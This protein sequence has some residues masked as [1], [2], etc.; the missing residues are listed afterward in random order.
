VAADRHRAWPLR[1]LW[2][3]WVV[4]L[5]LSLGL[6]LVLEVLSAS[7]KDARV[8]AHRRAGGELARLSVAAE[9]LI[10][11]EPA[12]LAELLA[13]TML[14]PAIE[15][16]FIVDP[17]RRIVLSSRVTDKGQ[18]LQLAQPELFALHAQT[19]TGD[20][21][22]QTEDPQTR[23]L[24][25]ARS[26]NWPAGEGELRG[27]GRGAVFVVVDMGHLIDGQWREALTDHLGQA[28]V[29]VL[30]CLLLFLGLEWLIARPVDRLREA[31]VRLGEGDL[32][33]R[34]PVTG[35]RELED[36][37]QAVNSMGA[38]LQAAVQRLQD[39]EQRFRALTESAP[40]AIITLDDGGRVDQFNGAAERLFGFSAA[41]MTGQLL[42][43]L[44]PPGT[45][46]VH[47]SLLARFAADM[48]GSGRRMQAG[49]VVKGL[50]RDGHLLHL[51]IGIS[52]SQAGGARSYTAMIRDV[53]DRVAVEDELDKHRRQLEDQVRQRTAEL[54]LERDRAQAAMRA[55]NEFLARMSH[56]IRTPMNAVVGLA[57]V[58][59]RGA[60]PSQVNQLQTLE[61]SALQLLALVDDILEFT[62]LEAGQVALLAAPADP[63]ALVHAVCQP[64]AERAARLGVELVEWVDAEVPDSVS[65][66]AQR[67]RQLLGHLVGN[68]VKFTPAGHITVHVSL[69]PT[70]LRF[71]VQDSGIGIEPAALNRLFKPFEQADPGDARRF[72]GA[73]L[74][75]V[76]TQRL[77]RLMGAELQAQSQPGQGSRFQFEV[78][79]PAVQGRGAPQRPLLPARQALVVESQADARAAQ[80]DL[81]RHLGVPAEGAASLQEARESLARFA[82]GGRPVDLCLVDAR[83]LADESGERADSPDPH[84]TLGGHRCVLAVLEGHAPPLAQ[85]LHAGYLGV[86]SKPL[87]CDAVQDRLVAWLS[88]PAPQRGATRPPA[89]QAAPAAPLAPGA[90]SDPV[91]MEA[92]EALHAVPGLDVAA[93]LRTLRGDVP[94]YRRLLRHFATFHGEDPARL[95]QL[96]ERGAGQDVADLAHSLKSSAG[97][98]GARAVVAAASAVPRH[99]EPLQ[100]TRRTGADLAAQMSSLLM[101]L[102]EILNLPG[103]A[104][105]APSAGDAGA[106]L[107]DTDPAELLLQLRA[108]L[109]RRDMAALRL[110]HASRGSLLAQLGAQAPRLRRAVEDFDF[111]VAL[112]LLDETLAARESTAHKPA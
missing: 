25:L 8:D 69:S 35:V 107:E 74:G 19:Q 52:H 12:V 91:G 18:L 77:L 59:R 98:I 27:P 96:L 101:A 61:D 6:W 16:A 26:L 75:L 57:H 94:A 89:P 2:A 72:G 9:S 78:R 20:G 14:D 17:Q 106:G 51:E 28:L 41:E 54:V 36:L 50:H 10:R 15:H 43:R 60:Q 82:D 4:L 110:L 65:L 49:R 29:L 22:I 111:D 31:A 38:S 109:E 32:A 47:A 100:D 24:V 67:L 84:T 108:S 23:R 39:S 5:S 81:L 73:G 30:A 62:R 34:V 93:G 42:D 63:R 11:R 112:K 103:H 87:S 85:V 58:V 105:A 3:A 44:L 33:H 86:L 64:L 48:P 21:L 13:H 79:A 104:A 66:D 102:G 99:G 68:A 95:Q 1:R 40:D 83:L 53:S 71:V 88:A 56:E 92:L 46:A 80:L 90:A 37:G 7:E 55:K 97:A 70:G 45:A 76:L